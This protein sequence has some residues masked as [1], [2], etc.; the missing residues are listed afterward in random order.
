MNSE[1]N[2][3][4]QANHDKL[5]VGHLLLQGMAAMYNPDAY[6]QDMVFEFHFTETGEDFQLLV[7]REECR[8]ISTG[9]H[10]YTVRIETS[11]KNLQTIVDSGAAGS[12]AL[13]DSCCTIQGDRTALSTLPALFSSPAESQP[14]DTSERKNGPEFILHAPLLALW[15]G[16]LFHEIWGAVL[17]LLI[18]I[19]AVKF[20]IKKRSSIPDYATV[21]A[22]VLGGL[23]CIIIDN[24]IPVII[25]TYIVLGAIW[26]FSC[27]TDAPLIIPSLREKFY[28]N[29]LD[30]IKLLKA[31]RMIS[32]LWALGYIIL[33]VLIYL[34]TTLHSQTETDSSDNTDI[35]CASII[36]FLIIGIIRRHLMTLY[37]K[38]D[39]KE[40]HKKQ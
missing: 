28:L 17:I 32:G 4:Q 13:T 21:A 10:H 20:F 36:V 1:N 22:G 2:T 7:F 6:T 12:D 9:F 30:R 33:G 26:L 8:V 27:F 16:V 25:A 29:R 37:F 14:D 40:N 38:A 34:Y 24:R 11:L 3:K 18:T 23:L 15:I 31:G 5:S 19:S 39:A 35:I